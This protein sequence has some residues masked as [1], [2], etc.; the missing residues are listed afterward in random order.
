MMILIVLS[1]I[2]CI[3]KAKVQENFEATFNTETVN[4]DF[5]AELIANVWK[6]RQEQYTRYNEQRNYHGSN[7]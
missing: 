7:S 2:F 3:N 4:L 5:I 6:Q 1:I